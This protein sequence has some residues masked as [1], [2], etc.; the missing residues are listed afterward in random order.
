MFIFNLSAKK[1]LL[2]LAVNKTVKCGEVAWFF[3]I[4]QFPV[5]FNIIV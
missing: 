4:S 1:G 2:R 5:I 3:H